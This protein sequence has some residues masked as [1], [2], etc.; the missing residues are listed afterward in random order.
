MGSL[1]GGGGLSSSSSS[2]ADSRSSF[3]TG[4]FYTNPKNDNNALLIALGAVA[5]I[6]LLMKK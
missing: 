3:G 4:D 2:S 1:T 5:L 6:V